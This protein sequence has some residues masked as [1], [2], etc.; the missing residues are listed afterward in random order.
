MSRAASARPEK[1]VD[2]GSPYAEFAI[3]L[4][5]LRAKSGLTYRELAERT[6]YPAAMLAEA[7]RGQRLPGLELTQAFVTACGGS[8]EEWRLQW[9]KI[10][11]RMGRSDRAKA[12]LLENASIRPEQISTHAEFVIALSALW[13]SAGLS[14][15]Q[16]ER[17]SDGRLRRSTLSNMLTGRAMPTWA[18]TQEFI[19]ICT[20]CSTTSKI[21]SPQWR[22]A[23]E[24]I[25][26]NADERSLHVLRRIPVQKCDPYQLGVH[27]PYSIGDE[28]RLPEYITRGDVE[29]KFRRALGE[30][31][32]QNG[33]ILLIG[34][35]GAGKSRL[36]Y[37]AA[38]SVLG[39]FGLLR[40]CRRGRS[41][42]GA[43]AT[44]SRLAR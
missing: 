10:N 42:D 6:R 8:D 27:R 34:Q 29:A 7:A 21:I 39:D 14:Y 30:A 38:R 31:K 40:P 23:W 9:A 43:A 18:T 2:P 12:Y 20:A 17:F 3:K 33:F 5:R 35:S 37:E 15:R 22:Y 36:A 11:A 32:S 28:G 13:K 16:V 26:A 41:R 24:R 1:P 19:S 4:R 44:H 25:R